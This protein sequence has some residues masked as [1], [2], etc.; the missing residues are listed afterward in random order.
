MSPTNTAGTDWT[1][2]EIDL[3]V[4]DYFDMLKL[5]I[6][7][8]TY[9]KAQRNAALQ[10][11]TGRSKGSIEFKHQNISAILL[12]L[13]LPWIQGYKPMSN[14]QNKLVERIEQFIEAEAQYLTTP[15]EMNYVGL[16]DGTILY[17]EAPP[18]LCSDTSRLS[19]V[20]ARLVRKFDPAARDS[21]NRA[22]G[23]QGEERVFYAERFRLSQAGRSDL[24]KMVRW[25]A[26]QDGD[27]AGY[28]ILSFDYH[29][30][31]RLLEVKTTAG[32]QTTP[33]FISENERRLSSERPDAFRIM[34]LYNVLIEPKAFEL[35]PPLEK[36]VF[37]NPTQ[38]RASF[39]S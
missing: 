39:G 19:P 2:D 38:F 13:G 8:V 30:K 36:S 6:A 25:V 24:A 35:V 9:V 22:L 4:A 15:K 10:E 3:I 34:R 5:E 28:D 12:E 26:D 7:G 37:L 27:G 32:H 17:V 31:E 11:L 20:L 29:G 33:F 14:Y 1:D 16:A 23:R 18:S 21:R